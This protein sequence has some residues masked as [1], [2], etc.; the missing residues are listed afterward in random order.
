MVTP[1]SLRGLIDQSAHTVDEAAI[2]FMKYFVLLVVCGVAH[3]VVGV[4]QLVSL[5]DSR[6]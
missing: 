4:A 6:F 1:T 3:P 2:M 5:K